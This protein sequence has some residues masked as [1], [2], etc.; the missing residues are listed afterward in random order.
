MARGTS[1]VSLV[2]ACVLIC[3]LGFEVRDKKHPIGRWS[4]FGPILVLCCQLG[5]VHVRLALLKGALLTFS[6]FHTTGLH[7]VCML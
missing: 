7:C 3:E 1:D 4:H 6:S 2:C 5:G